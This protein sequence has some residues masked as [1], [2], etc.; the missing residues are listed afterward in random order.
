MAVQ[1]MDIRSII[2]MDYKQM[3]SYNYDYISVEKKYDYGEIGG[4]S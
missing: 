4:V 3:R 1:E 2:Q